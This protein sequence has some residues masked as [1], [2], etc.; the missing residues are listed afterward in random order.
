MVELGVLADGLAGC[1][2]SPNSYSGHITLWPG[3]ILESNV[4]EH[5]L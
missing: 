3:S 5:D 1:A 4:P 2:P